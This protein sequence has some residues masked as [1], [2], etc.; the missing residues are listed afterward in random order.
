MQP[1]SI[2]SYASGHSREICSDEE[3]PMELLANHSNRRSNPPSSRA[4]KSW[5]SKQYVGVSPAS[6]FTQSHIPVS[7]ETLQFRKHA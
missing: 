2:E 3:E 5:S 1:T 4:T 7:Q 6:L